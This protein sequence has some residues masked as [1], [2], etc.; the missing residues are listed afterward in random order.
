[1]K[2]LYRFAIFNAKWEAIQSPNAFEMRSIIMRFHMGL[3]PRQSEIHSISL[4]VFR[5]GLLL[6][7]F[8]QRFLIPAQNK[9]HSTL[10]PVLLVRNAVYNCIILYINSLG[11]KQ[12]LLHIIWCLKTILFFI[13]FIYLLIWKYQLTCTYF[14]LCK[15]LQIHH[16]KPYNYRYRFEHRKFWAM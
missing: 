11:T 5:S 4:G 14:T 1:M 7:S 16:V 15:K 12:S 13:T 10:L 9:V 2:T 8:I 3:Q 6:Y